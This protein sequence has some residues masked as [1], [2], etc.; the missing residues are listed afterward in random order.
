MDV[1]LGGQGAPIVPIGEMLLLQEYGLFLNLGGI[2][3]VSRA[4]TRGRMLMR[5]AERLVVRRR[6]LWRPGA[7]GSSHSMYARRTGY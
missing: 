5:G 1:A 6:R 7:A 4:G 2:A 3:N